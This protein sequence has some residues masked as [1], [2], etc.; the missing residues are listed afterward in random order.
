MRGLSAAAGW[1]SIAV[2]AE[3]FKAAQAAIGA[4]REAE[5]ADQIQPDVTVV[6]PMRCAIEALCQIAIALQIREGWINRSLESDILPN[7]HAQAEM[8]MLQ[9]IQ[10]VFVAAIKAMD[11]TA[12]IP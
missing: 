5:L 3:L 4:V 8:A 12:A 6:L 7:M 11:E 9:Q 10:A 2:K 1:G